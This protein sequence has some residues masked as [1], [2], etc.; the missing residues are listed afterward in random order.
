MAEI[1]VKYNQLYQTLKSP[2][3]KKKFISLTK[4][5]VIIAS[6]DSVQ[7]YI[8]GVKYAHILPITIMNPWEHPIDNGIRV[9]NY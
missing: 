4:N 2:S 1:W 7:Q 9:D 5:I 6:L 8:L 3:S